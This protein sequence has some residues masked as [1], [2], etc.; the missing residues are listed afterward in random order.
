MPDL[1]IY[2]DRELL[3]KPRVCQD[4][5]SKSTLGIQR[6]TIAGNRDLLITMIAAYL[7]RCNHGI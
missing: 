5:I 7:K 4:A 6:H 2:P 1:H 3:V